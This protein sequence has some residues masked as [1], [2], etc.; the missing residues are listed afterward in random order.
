MPQRNG[1]PAAE[2]VAM[3]GR[4]GCWVIIVFGQLGRVMSAV[5]TEAPM[6][7]ARSQMMVMPHRKGGIET[8]LFA[9]SVVWA[10]RRRPSPSC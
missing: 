10:W 6:A 4:K 9:G 2:A 8:S 7:R 1:T 3:C 5:V